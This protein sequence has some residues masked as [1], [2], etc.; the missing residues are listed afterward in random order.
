MNTTKAYNSIKKILPALPEA[1][2]DALLG[3]LSATMFS[4][5]P[6]GKSN[7]S[8]ES[9]MIVGCCRLILRVQC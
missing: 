8:N 2:R 1:E 9:I 4:I 5:W 7:C 3:R 6:V